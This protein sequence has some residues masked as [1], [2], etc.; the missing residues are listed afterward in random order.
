LVM[1]GW[2]TFSSCLKMEGLETEA[3]MGG[4]FAGVNCRLFA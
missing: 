3:L 4:E 2:T 1:I